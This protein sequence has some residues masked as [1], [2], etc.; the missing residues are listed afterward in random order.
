[1]KL[2][3]VARPLYVEE[4]IRI[5]GDATPLVDAVRR[6]ISSLEQLNVALKSISGANVRLLRTQRTQVS[7]TAKVAST[8][9]VAARQQSIYA[10]AVQ[11]TNVATTANTRQ[12][13]VY[14]AAV[15]A[16]TRRLQA[17][18]A[19]QAQLAQLGPG[20]SG[21]LRGGGGRGGRGR[22][23]GTTPNLFGSPNFRQIQA[24]I[25]QVRTLQAAVKSLAAS[26]LDL[27]RLIGISLAIGGAF[28]I[29]GAIEEGIDASIEFSEAIAEI[30]TIQG[31]VALSTGAW[32]EELRILSDSFGIS[33][34]DEAE[35]AYQAISNQVVQTTQD[36]VF[37]EAANKL[38]L[39]TVSEASDAVNLLS[40]ALKAFNIDALEAEDVSGKFFKTVELGRVRA[41]ELANTF[42]RVGIF[43][44]QLGVSLDETLA[45]IASITVQG[46]KSEE[47][48][49]LLRNIF[50]KL[51]D[52]T[53]ELNDLLESQGFATGEA[54]IASRDLA[55]V[56]ALVEQVTRGSSSEIAALFSRIRASI[57]VSSLIGEQF[58]TFGENL[59]EISGAGVRDVNDAANEIAQS[60]GRQ[61][62]IEG[63][64][65]RNFFEKDI[66]LAIVESLAEIN[67]SIGGFTELLKEGA[68][69][70][71][72]YGA[73][74][75]IAT[76]LITAYAAGAVVAA[77][78]NTGLGASFVAAQLAVLKFTKALLVN[79]IFL[80][81]AA[82]ALATSII[83]ENIAASYNEALRAAEQANADLIKSQDEAAAANAK[84]QAKIVSDFVASL[85]VETAATIEATATI[86]KAARE[87]LE[88]ITEVI[89]DLAPRVNTALKA[90]LDAF[91]TQISLLNKDI[92]TLEGNVEDSA[93]GIR[94]IFEEAE[95]DLFEAR[96]DR[97][98]GGAQVSAI[99]SRIEDLN[100]R[101]ARSI[102]NLNREA[103]E[104]QLEQ[105]RKLSEERLKVNVE[106]ADQQRDLD[107][108]LFRARQDLRNAD[109]RAERNLARE[110]IR[111]IEKERRLRSELS[112]EEA[113]A[114]L[115]V[116]RLQRQI[117]TSPRGQQ[118]D[119]LRDQL[120]VARNE[121]KLIQE[122][123]EAERRAREENFETI[124]ETAQRLAELAAEE[125][126]R[127]R[128]L[129]IQQ[130]SIQSQFDQ[131]RELTNESKKFR[132]E[133]VAKID[134]AEELDKAFQDQID[135]LKEIQRINENLGLTDQD[136][137]DIA[138]QIANLEAAR[139]ARGTQLR[140][141]Q[142]QEDIQVRRQEA[143]TAA[144]DIFE[145]AR[146]LQANLNNFTRV[147]G[148]AAT[149]FQGG[150][151]LFREG[152]I[153]RTG[154]GF[155]AG[156]RGVPNVTVRL[157]Q[158]DLGRLVRSLQTELQG[159]RDPERIRSLAT[160]IE[161]ALAALRTT[162]DE[163]RARARETETEISPANQA[164][165][166]ILGDLSKVV[167]DALT[168]T[169]T[170]FDFLAVEQAVRDLSDKEAVRIA[171]EAAAAEAAKKR[172]EEAGRLAQRISDLNKAV[173]ELNAITE[174]PSI[175]A[176]AARVALDN[177]KSELDQSNKEFA[178][179][180]GLEGESVGEEL[181]AKLAEGGAEAGI[182]FERARQAE[183]QRRKDEEARLA[184]EAAEAE[185]ARGAPDTS[186]AARIEQKLI[187]QLENLSGEDRERALI[188]LVEFQNRNQRDISDFAIQELPQ[189]IL[190]QI[191]EASQRNQQLAL[192]ALASAREQNLAAAGVLPFDQQQQLT[193][194]ANIF[195]ALQRPER[196]EEFQRITP[197]L[198]A[199]VRELSPE[200][201]EVVVNFGDI[202]LEGVDNPRQFAGQIINELNRAL[203]RGVLEIR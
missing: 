102:V 89:G 12:Q 3:S 80:G 104:A 83:V 167:K 175:Q 106:V 87:D 73:S 99:T 150:A 154:E 34:L 179:L 91:R 13:S 116:F 197:G 75:A 200:A 54:L 119:D 69:F 144:R 6:A 45:G 26:F 129:A 55:G 108:R 81:L 56:L 2:Y 84:A 177:L 153:E 52:P 120:R 145:A 111:E 199:Q 180:F 76:T 62:T 194:L 57:G 98:G 36:F 109:S 105:I 66:G 198:R 63:Q 53:S 86:A 159:G 125:A 79:P 4:R 142:L 201:Q 58:K 191:A 18:A 189:E 21:R 151:T 149:S 195:D 162:V 19:A 38:A 157:D 140:A 44:N 186:I 59:S 131:L 64:R 193:Q 147:I 40:S 20:L 117:A 65:I 23:L 67:K 101:V 148:A 178:E 33:I 143:E 49:T 29:V 152:F 185:L 155:F 41:D 166:A 10:A 171:Q 110:K 135:R 127:A 156:G 137:L 8:N 68:Q 118:R 138:Q 82:V 161:P 50:L 60:A 9:A 61:L 130:A 93:D 71:K 122:S 112:E 183:I 25:R 96:L 74:I 11:A 28:R 133:E 85:K 172:E 173:T 163:I 126:A 202:N 139:Q 196:T 39:A 46:V 100:E 5:T 78:A 164:T 203:R 141:F 188:R 14:A 72:D 124:D 182:N 42:G 70:V 170:A 158:T 7:T 107:S 187:K 1:M 134:D 16:T 168:G 27:G 123:V 103:V 92:N 17:Q 128:D 174:D 51:A 121:Q 192:S 22:G 24:G 47:A 136:R 94:E 35:A 97:L 48:L 146:P 190:G 43:A 95:T 160:Q 181:K 169:D 184:R 90:G 115:A 114:A 88:E 176:D 132:L 32:A 77:T 30:R 15:A 113:D 37:F 31:D 165:I